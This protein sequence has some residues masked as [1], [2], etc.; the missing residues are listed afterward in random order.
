MLRFSTRRHVVSWDYRGLYGS[1]F[2]ASGRDMGVLAHARDALSVLDQ[3]G[4]KRAAFF[5]WSM[6]AQ[7]GLELARLAPQRIHALVLLNGSVGKPLEKLLGPKAGGLVPGLVSQLGRYSKY[8]QKTLN[9]AVRFPFTE[10]VVRGA[11]LIGSQFSRRD[12]ARL[13]PEFGRINIARYLELLKG[14]AEH[15]AEP[16]LDELEVPTLIL[17]SSGDHI[18]E[19][20]AARGLSR[21]IRNAE[22]REISWASHY[23]A[24]EAPEQVFE[25]VEDFLARRVDPKPSPKVAAD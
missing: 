4:E 3:V 20:R 13:L 16:F 21:R 24:L 7:V 18:T 2:E 12:F 1:N 6:G 19:A 14:I 11:G 23:A 9:W 10:Q 22:Y 25:A 17:G 15:D 5:G 8:G